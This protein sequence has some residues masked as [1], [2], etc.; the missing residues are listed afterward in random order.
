MFSSE[1]VI[2]VWNSFPCDV[3]NVSSVK[4]FKRSLHAIDLSGF[5]NCTGSIFGICLCVVFLL[6][7][8]YFSTDVIK[9]FFKTKTKTKTL[10]SRPRPRPRL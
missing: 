9:T 6:G 5:C 8:L 3:T 4:A 7:I 10:V 1:R 2:N